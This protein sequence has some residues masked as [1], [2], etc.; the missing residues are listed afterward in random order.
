[1]ENKLVTTS[2]V[3]MEAPKDL[4][5]LGFRNIKIQNL[6][7]VGQVVVGIFITT[8]WVLEEDSQVYP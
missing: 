7:V 8:R 6:G 3:V 5:G 1:M 2:W 4:G